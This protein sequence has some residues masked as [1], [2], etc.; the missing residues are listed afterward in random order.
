MPEIDA[1]TWRLE[2]LGDGLKDGSVLRLSLQDLRTLFPRAEVTT[3]L[4]CAGNRRGDMSVHAKPTRGLAWGIGA[5][6]NVQFAGARLRDVLEWAGLSDDAVGKSVRH[7]HFEGLD[8]DPATGTHYAASIPADRAMDAHADVLLAYEMN[9]EALTR[10][11]L[12]VLH[13]ASCREGY[14]RVS[15]FA[16]R[17][18]GFPLR[19]VVPGIVSA[20]QV[21]WLG[22]IIPSQYEVTRVSS[23]PQSQSPASA[24]VPVQ[25]DSLWQAKDYKAFP[26]GMD[27]NTVDFDC[28]PSLQVSRRTACRYCC[29]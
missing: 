11:V 8:C 21:K 27:W 9:G 4:Q 2:V 22:R 20:R 13:V 15:H 7:I 17:D 19:V 25:S 29:V 18:H 1:A 10:F 3:V 23:M 26:Q 5:M 6:G 24:L 16:C 12:G 14:R 28:M